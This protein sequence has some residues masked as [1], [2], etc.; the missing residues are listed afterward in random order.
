MK[1]II[2]IIVL[3][4]SFS[5]LFAQPIYQQLLKTAEERYKAGEW[6][7]AIE[8]YSLYLQG[9]SNPDLAY[10]IEIGIYF[11]NKIKT[12]KDQS[13]TNILGVP[14]MS[15]DGKKAIEYFNIY[16]NSNSQ[17]SSKSNTNIY[18]TYN[19]LAETYAIEKNWEKSVE[20]ATKIYKENPDF[21]IIK[22]NNYTA[23]QLYKD[24]KNAYANWLCDQA[25]LYSQ[26]ENDN[27]E[28]K[29]HYRKALQFYNDPLVGNAIFNRGWAYSELGEYEKAKND[30]ENYI[31]QY[32][33]LN[34]VSVAKQELES[35]KILMA[36]NSDPQNSNS[37]TFERPSYKG[38]TLYYTGEIKNGKANGKGE[39]TT[40]YNQYYKGD[41]VDNEY[42]GIGLHKW[43]NGETYEGDWVFGQR[44][45]QGTYKWKDGGFYSGG[46]QNGQQIGK[47]TCKYIYDNGTYTGELLNN[48]RHG[49]G[50]YQWASGDVYTGDWVNGNRTGYG[51]YTYKIDGKIIEGK[52]EN[53][54]Y[55]PTNTA[56][57]INTN[58]NNINIEKEEER[59]S[60]AIKEKRYNDAIGIYT[61]LI[62]KKGGAYH[63]FE[64]GK[65]Y[66]MLK[67]YEKA[68]LD[69]TSSI[70]IWNSVQTEP[71][72]FLKEDAINE[73]RNIE[74]K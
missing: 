63:Y 35:I 73:L 14:E 54:V 50:T 32:P 22:S 36:L 1:N 27:I 23:T 28:A 10:N 42:H 47:G 20:Y 60:L 56:N 45:G 3:N 52:W 8:A 13:L 57:P 7:G 71:M 6:D 16:L 61:L 29:K 12:K 58:A 39:A 41:F 37:L 26:N 5:Q 72:S 21:V 30:L 55:I 38:E 65:V 44:T 18:L 67:N 64:R 34:F 4:L 31:Q 25:N 66:S 11:L 40:S 69:F 46:F 17:I 33:D 53:N 59:A 15:V 51:K 70:S 24:A 74:N 48:V 43:A 62:E 2:L 49:K 9:A 19:Y 68:R